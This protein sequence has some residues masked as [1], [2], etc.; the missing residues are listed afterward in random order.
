MPETL[1]NDAPLMRRRQVPDDWNPQNSDGQF[2]GPITRARGAGALEEPGQHARAAHRS[3]CPA[4]QWVGRFGF[5]GDKQ[6]DNLTFALGAGSVTPLQMASAYAVFANGGYRV[7]PV[8]IERIVD[9]QGQVL[10]EAPPA[11]RLTE[12]QRVLPERNVFLV[13][14]LL[15][16]VT[17]AAPRR[18]RRPRCSARPVRQDRHHQRRRRRLVRRLPAR[19]WWRWPGWATT[20]RAAW[21]NAS[22]AA[23]WRCRRGSTTW[24]AR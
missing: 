9:A 13:R 10:F 16:D 1:V 6:P 11:G 17:R 15:A 18:A 21:A 23:A 22:R 3:A 8:L 7:A 24:P 4:R 5:D 14:S 19:A 12:D 20:N 2:D